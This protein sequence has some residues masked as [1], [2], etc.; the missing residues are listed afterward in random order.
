MNIAGAA[1]AVGIALSAVCT[2]GALFAFACG[3]AT[4]E[5][6]GASRARPTF[7]ILGILLA[8]VIVGVALIGAAA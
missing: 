7:V 4:L 6:Y 2:L 5:V 3:M 1:L 8:G